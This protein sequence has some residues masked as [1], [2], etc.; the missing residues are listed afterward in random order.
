MLIRQD[1]LPKRAR[2]TFSV[3][4]PCFDGGEALREFHRRLSTVMAGLRRPWEVVYVNDGHGDEALHHLDELHRT[5]SRVALVNLSRKHGKEIALTAGLNHALGEAIVIIDANLRHPP[6][7]IPDLIAAWRQGSDIVDAPGRISLAQTGLETTSFRRMLY[8]G[9]ARSPSANSGDFKLMSRR[10]VEVFVER[11]HRSEKARTRKS[12]FA[13]K[14]ILPD[15]F[16]RGRE[17][18]DR[19][20]LKLEKLDVD[21]VGGV[22]HRLLT[23][24]RHAG[25]AIVVAAMIYGAVIFGRAAMFGDIAPH[26][27]CVIA[28]VLFLGGIQLMT[29]GVAGEYLGRRS[30]VCR[31]KTRW[32]NEHRMS[33]NLPQRPF[34]LVS[35]VTATVGFWSMRIVATTLGETAADYVSI[36]LQIGF[37]LSAL[38][39]LGLYVLALVPHILAPRNRQSQYWGVLLSM[40]MAGTAMSDVMNSC[41]HLGYEAAASIFLALVLLTDGLQRFVLRKSK[42]VA[43]VPSSKIAAFHWTSLLF[44]SAFGTTI[45]DAFAGSFDLSYGAGALAICGILALVALIQMFGKAATVWLAR[46]PFTLTQS[47]GAT[48]G[49]M[50]SK[51]HIEGGRGLGTVG[52]S[53][54]LAVTLI[55]LLFLLKRRLGD[56]N[57]P[58]LYDISQSALG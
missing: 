38:L 15:R 32:A 52:S 27:P 25:L 17:T 4:V 20:G 46:I 19:N 8:G 51:S 41:D 6:E 57:R 49:D 5:D 39:L 35:Q 7:L 50:L 21:D 1:G 55:G 16:A 13:S 29:V 54:L 28:L 48:L 53:T 42:P 37:V 43:P 34:D 10:A 33:P 44:L 23:A 2:P 11:Q 40:A 18:T 58:P 30:E 12:P 3:V 24:A 31:I 56:N 14:P 26:Q 9:S 22:V 45:G 47:L 36:T